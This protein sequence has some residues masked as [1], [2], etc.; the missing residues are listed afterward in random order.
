[1]L[2]CAVPKR[3]I[4]GLMLLTALFSAPLQASAPRCAINPAGIAKAS[5]AECC[6]TMKWCALPQRDSQ[7]TAASTAQD[8]LVTIA[9]PLVRLLVA[10]LPATP[11]QFRR[12]SSPIGHS[13]VP[14]QALLCVF[15]I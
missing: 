14:R 6:A 9:A 2:R 11:V 10:E 3:L 13:S 8:N 7:P 4:V 5:C 12:V 15:L 1:M